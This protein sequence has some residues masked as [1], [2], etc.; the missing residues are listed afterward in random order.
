MND[1]VTLDFGEP[2]QVNGYRLN[3][4]KLEL[5]KD[6]QVLNPQSAWVSSYRESNKGEKTLLR[7]PIDTDSLYFGEAQALL[8]YDRLFAID[9]SSEPISGK[10][11]S[12]GCF[13][14]CRFNQEGHQLI[15][16]SAV[17]GSI[18]FHGV[19]NKQENMAWHI[20][21]KAILASPDYSSNH[22]YGIITDSDL[23]QHGAYNNRSTPYFLD[24]IL[25]ANMT[26]IYAFD[27]GRSLSNQIIKICDKQA[28]RMIQRFKRGELSLQGASEVQSGVCSHFR[29]WLNSN[30]DVNAIQWFKISQFPR[31][32]LDNTKV[33]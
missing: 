1:T 30:S 17:L 19:T 31:D 6:G 14:E 21:I 32:T 28:R 2:V 16:Q 15:F 25:P 24:N 9:T 20:L 22:R 5:L 33:A 8:G 13:A 11:I 12:V 10:D 23:G 4:G 7:V 3:N 29:G 18:E 26:L 27:K